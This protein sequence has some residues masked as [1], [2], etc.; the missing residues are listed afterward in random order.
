MSPELPTFSEIMRNWTWKPIPDCPGR[1]KLLSSDRRLPVSAI[2]GDMV[3]IEEYRVR[4]ARDVVLVAE[5]A[6]GGVISY[7]RSDGTYLHTLNT[8]A[9]FVRKLRQLGIR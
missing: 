6:D 2:I 8:A 3:P 1:Y 4:A 5:L 9:D 7:R